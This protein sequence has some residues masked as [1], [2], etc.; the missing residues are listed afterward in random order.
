MLQGAADRIKNRFRKTKNSCWGCRKEGR[1]AK[2]QKK[3]KKKKKKKMEKPP[4]P[5]NRPERKKS[6]IHE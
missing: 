2:E 6:N 3:K 1:D 4:P 5:P